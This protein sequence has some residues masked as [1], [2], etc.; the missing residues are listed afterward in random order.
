MHFVFMLLVSVV[1][2]GVAG[3]KMPPWA[4]MLAFI[5]LVVLFFVAGYSAARCLVG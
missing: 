5:L 3:K 2:V 4:G 1:L